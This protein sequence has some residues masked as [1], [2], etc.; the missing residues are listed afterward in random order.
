MNFLN[1]LSFFLAGLLPIIILMYLLR[2]RRP[3]QMVSST[4]LWQR[5][6][7]DVEANAPW[8]KLQKNIIMILQLLFLASLIFAIA[9]P[10]LWTEGIGGSSMIIIIDSSASMAATDIEPS[11]LEAAKQQAQAFTEEAPE[12]TRITVIS[13]GEQTEILVS[14]SQDRKLTQQ[15][16]NSISTPKGSS[17]F[18]TALQITSAITSRQPNTDIILLSDGNIILPEQL[19]IQG[20]FLYYPIGIES[21]NLGI[22]NIQ[23]QQNPT[24]DNNTLFVQVKNFGSDAANRRLEIYADDALINAAD[25]N[26]AAQSIENYLQEGIALESKVVEV[27]LSPSD[28]F[29][30]DD[31][32]WVIGGE[33]K[34]V[35]ILLVTAGNRFLET[36]LGLL[37]NISYSKLD[38]LS[39]ETTNDLEADL[40]IFDG[41]TPQA[42][43]LPASNLF[44]I[45]AE[46]SNAFYE[47]T[48]TVEKPKPRPANTDNPL[49]KN[50]SLD[51]VSI[52]QASLI[53]L[54]NWANVSISGD[55][56]G[57]SIPL[58]FY[59]NQAGQR[60]AVLSFK[61][62][63]SDLPIQVAFPLLIANIVNWLVPNAI[64]DAPPTTQSSFTTSVP[65]PLDVSEVTIQYP[66]GTK[67]QKNIDQSGT[68]LFNTPFPGIYIIDLGDGNNILTASNF[69]SL[70]ESDISPRQQLN[71]GSSE[72]SLNTAGLQQSQKHFWR[73]IAFV[74][75]GVL[76]SEWLVYH[77]GTLA[78]VAS[79]VF[80]REKQ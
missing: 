60:I 75:L 15:A 1:P 10:F 25:L 39:F 61:I 27:R 59:G 50:I 72:G 79:T 62:Q 43:T 13:A 67:T 63:D 3:Q 68:L 49:L 70:Q 78:K 17:D 23:L 52:R 64:L 71:L 36:A 48:G 4:F 31:S 6:V 77:R 54:P 24:G 32:A 33:L 21:A 65:I 20:N 55:V 9:N 44:F 35:E 22:T 38:P 53:T 19:S 8:Q 40:V 46:G 58:L 42:D 45:G 7:R 5:M 41:Y 18:S 30:N 11:R 73:P 34:P 80:R 47:V 16:I 69:F 12:N 57:S 74:A 29:P 66:D 2:L 56:N 28:L 26:V 51:G 76:I 14:A 37:P